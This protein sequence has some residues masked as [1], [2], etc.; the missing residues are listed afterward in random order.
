MLQR[1]T[2]FLTTLQ[3]LSGLFIDEETP[4]KDCPDRLLD[5]KELGLTISSKEESMSSRLQAMAG[6]VLKLD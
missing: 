1:G 5:I 4:I 6:W 2:N 3:T